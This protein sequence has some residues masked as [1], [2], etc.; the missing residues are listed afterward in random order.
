MTLYGWLQVKAHQV[1]MFQINAA[2]EYKLLN[3]NVITN[4]KNFNVGLL[5][6]FFMAI[7]LLQLHVHVYAQVSKQQMAAANQSHLCARISIET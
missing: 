4:F 3:Y 7:S 1:S 2:A 6:A 5:L